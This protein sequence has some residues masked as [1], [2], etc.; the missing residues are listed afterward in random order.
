MF[1]EF[2]ASYREPILLN[3]PDI[4]AANGIVWG[5]LVSGVAVIGEPDSKHAGHRVNS[6]LS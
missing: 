3:T 5:F 4:A 6:D 2:A 1:I